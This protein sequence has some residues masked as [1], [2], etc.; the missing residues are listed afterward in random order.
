MKGPI[1][2]PE[3]CNGLMIPILVFDQIYSFDRDALIKTIPRPDR[4]PA[5]DFATAA[6]ELFDRMM[7]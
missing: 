1:A 6:E 5:K 4:I 3:V 7:R 2:P